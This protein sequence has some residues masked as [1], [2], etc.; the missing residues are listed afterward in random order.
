MQTIVEK[1]HLRKIVGEDEFKLQIVAWITHDLR[2][3]ERGQRCVLPQSGLNRT[4]RPYDNGIAD[5][6]HPRQFRPVGCIPVELR[7]FDGFSNHFNSLT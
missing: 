6:K 7:P 1:N 3:G 2:G 5:Q 4:S